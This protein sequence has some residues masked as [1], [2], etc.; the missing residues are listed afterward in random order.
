[1]KRLAPHL[2]RCRTKRDL[3]EQE[4]VSYEPLTCYIT[5]ALHVMRSS[6]LWEDDE[7]RCDSAVVDLLRCLALVTLPGS[8]R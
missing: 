2:S 7:L 6:K 8:S 1:M 5:L 4:E 3:G